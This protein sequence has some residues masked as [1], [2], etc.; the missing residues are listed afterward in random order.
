MNTTTLDT[1]RVGDAPAEAP[2]T[3]SIGRR[4][5]LLLAIQTVI[6]LGVLLAFR[7]LATSSE[8]D[9]MRAVGLSY[10]RLLRMPY[11]ITLALVGVNIALVFYIQPVSRY[12]ELVYF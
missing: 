10:N 7:K 5:S 6:G 1:P 3:Y 11:I 2:C 9:T 8:L 12:A 4:L